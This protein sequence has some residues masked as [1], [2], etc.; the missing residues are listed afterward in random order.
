MY[1]EIY[2]LTSVIA[3]VDLD[4]KYIIGQQPRPISYNPIIQGNKILLPYFSSI[5][6]T[7]GNPH[8]EIEQI[9]ENC[10]RY[11]QLFQ[12]NKTEGVE[13]KIEKSWKNF[14]PFLSKTT[15]STRIKIN[16]GE[17]FDICSKK[18]GTKS[19]VVISG[20]FSIWIAE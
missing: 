14:I 3:K 20:L 1:L 11:Y 7:I 4:K 18:D 5:A 10:A 9:S 19:F 6:K 15:K 17:F 16:K 13:E 8:A 2:H 12:T